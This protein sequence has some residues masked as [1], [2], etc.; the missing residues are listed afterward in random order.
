MSSSR[1]RERRGHRFCVAS[2][3][4]G[5][6]RQGVDTEGSSPASATDRARVLVF[7]GPWDP[8]HDAIMRIEG[9]APGRRFHSSRR[10]NAHVAGR[11]TAASDRRRSPALCPAS[12][13][14]GCV[15][16]SFSRSRAQ[17]DALR[18]LAC[19]RH[20]PECNQQLSRQRHDHRLA[21][22]AAG[23]GRPRPIPLRQRA[24]LLEDEEAPGELDQAA[25]HPRVTRLGETLLPSPPAAL[26]RRASEAG[27]AGDRCPASRATGSRSRAC[28]QSRCRSR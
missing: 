21:R 26:V 18:D 22:G 13:P 2:P 5:R 24:I 20:A 8:D 23:V 3:V 1:A 17:R 19:R 16:V 28:P 14:D 25:P 9:E 6:G 7:G 10:C 27:I 4:A 15:P 12:G 11:V